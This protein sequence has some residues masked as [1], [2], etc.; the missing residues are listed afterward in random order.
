[1]IFLI[2]FLLYLAQ[3]PFGYEPAPT[4]LS[5]PTW[6]WIDNHYYYCTVGSSCGGTNSTGMCTFGG[7]VCRVDLTASVQPGDLIVAM[8]TN[9]SGSPSYISSISGET[10]THCA[11][12]LTTDLGG[13]LLDVVYMSAHGG[14][15]SVTCN[16]T[17]APSGWMG[18]LVFVARWS[19]SGGITFDGGNSITKPCGI[20]CLGLTIPMTGNTDLAIQ[21]NWPINCD[22]LT[23]GNGVTPPWTMFQLNDDAYVLNATSALGSMP[24]T[25][26]LACMDP[27]DALNASAFTGH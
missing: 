17:A 1:V 16:M 10:I 25:W 12:C 23:G 8:S 3:I 21:M 9:Y 18:C 19:G 2:P 4:I 15:T 20:P 24:P 5:G 11:P 7:T 22:T 26:T 13:L 6:S 27:H 14:E